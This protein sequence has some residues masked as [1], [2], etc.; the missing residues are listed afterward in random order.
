[1]SQIA[2][3]TYL[4]AFDVP[5]LGFWSKPKPRLFRKPECKFDELLRP[6]VLREQL[7]EE[8]DGVYVAL[9]FV[10]LK[11]VDQR[12]SWEADPIIDSVRKNIGGS[13]WL[14]KFAD[15]RLIQVFHNPL[16]EIE[17]RTFLTKMNIESESEFDWKSFNVTAVFVRD[18]LS[19]LKPSEALLTSTG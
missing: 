2:S 9:V 18:R 16:A 15:Q 19:D 10:W 13:H 12:F 11:T 5:H 1:M 4:K 3:F 14:M 7:F 6:H 8:A 17:W